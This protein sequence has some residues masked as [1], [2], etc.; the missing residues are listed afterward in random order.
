VIPG[1]TLDQGL[2]PLHGGQT[3]ETSTQ[4]LDN[5]DER[6]KQYYKDG[7]RFAKWRSAFSIKG[8]EVLYQMA[9]AFVG[10]IFCPYNGLGN[11]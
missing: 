4:G 10:K 11:E 5:M 2:V 9:F 3:G 8:N 7:L 6:C 1:V